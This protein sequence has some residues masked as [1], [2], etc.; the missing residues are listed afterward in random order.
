MAA[1]DAALSVT[2]G[3]PVLLWQTSTG[4]SPDAAIAGQVFRAGTFDSPIPILVRNEDA[5]HNATLGGSAV[6]A[7]SGPSLRAGESLT[8]NIVGNDSLYAIAN[9]NTVTITVLVQR[10]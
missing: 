10:Q 2:T 6:T 8:F 7:N 5:T 9:T 1:V 3:A 4:V